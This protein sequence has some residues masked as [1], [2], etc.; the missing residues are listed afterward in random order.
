M[1]ITQWGEFGALCCIYMAR[2]QTDESTRENSVSAAELSHALSIPLQYTQ[3]ILQRLRKGDVII[4]VR[5]P[6][7]GYL[8][9]KDPKQITLKDILSAAEGET[10]EIICEHKTVLEE[11]HEPGFSCGLKPV[12]YELKDAVDKL[13]ASKTLDLLANQAQ[14][15]RF[16]LVQ[17][18]KKN[19]AESPVS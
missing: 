14:D 5:G 19:V 8:L 1:R 10:F 7:G 2:K 15:I 9:S 17:L 11:C 13:L 4:S 16:G 6:G 18:N 12:W 3:Q